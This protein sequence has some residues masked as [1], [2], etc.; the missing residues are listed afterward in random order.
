LQSG[1]C[2]VAVLQLDDIIYI[3]NLGDS[4]AVMGNVEGEVVT[5]LELST[6]HKPY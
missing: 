3:A 1:S 2:G 6:D 5:A 4:R